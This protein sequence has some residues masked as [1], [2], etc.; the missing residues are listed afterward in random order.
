MSQKLVYLG[1]GTN[2]GDRRTNLVEALHRLT[3]RVEIRAV[4]RLYETAPAYVL[5]QPNF[6]NI[7]LKGETGLTPSQLL[8]FLKE[9]EVNLGRQNSVRYGPRHI[10][11]D[12]LFYEDLVV[13]LPNLHIPHP[14]LAERAFAL[15]PLADI[16]PELVHPLT[17]QTII[18]LVAN[19]PADDGV[20]SVTAWEFP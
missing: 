13:N 9:T 7:A 15:R 1:L 10:D 16:A 2:L 17:R 3:E 4:S 20:L 5:D 18:E 19:L 6:L 8:T 14:R 12:I 11:L